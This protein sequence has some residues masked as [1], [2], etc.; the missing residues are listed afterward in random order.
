MHVAHSTSDV[1][2]D[3]CSVV[4]VL[5]MHIHGS[6]SN[7]TDLVQL[8]EV[9]THLGER[10]T[11]ADN[12]A[13]NVLPRRMVKTVPDFDR[14]RPELLSLWPL[15]LLPRLLRPW[16]LVLLAVLLPRVSLVCCCGA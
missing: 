5:I 3:T 2:A 12:R 9:R 7:N 10:G 16:A 6:T 8:G 15:V 1:I 13:A 11:R 14:D 4:V